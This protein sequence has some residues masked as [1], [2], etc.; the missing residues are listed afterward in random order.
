MA[1]NLESSPLFANRYRF[2]QVPT[3]WDTGRSGFTHLVFDMEKERLG[4]I[5][6]AELK[7]RQAVE[8]LKNEVAVLLDLK[9]QNVPEVYETGEAEYGSKKYFYMVIEYIDG[10][11][12]EK[13][14]SALTVPERADIITQFFDLLANAHKLGIVNG[15]VDLKHLFWRDKKQLVVI[16]WGN[17]KLNAGSKNKTDLAYDLARSAEI[18]YALTTKKGHPPATGSLSLPGNSALFPGLAPLPTEFYELCK[19][20]PRTPVDGAHFKYSA[21]ELLDVSQKWQKAIRSKKAYKAPSK[22]RSWVLGILLL[23]LFL[24]IGFSVISPSS[25]FYNLFHPATVTSTVIASHTIAPSVTNTPIPTAENTET[26]LPPTITNTPPPTPLPDLSPTPITPTAIPGPRVYTT[27][28]ILAEYKEVP[29]SLSSICLPVNISTENNL[30]SN[31]G[32]YPR[33]DSAQEVNYWGFR[34]DKEHT[35]Y[36]KDQTINQAI[37]SDF[38]QCIQQINAISLNTWVTRLDLERDSPNYD[39][40]D[41]GQEI[42][43]FIDNG[44]GLRREYTIWV[45]K[46]KLMHVRVRENNEVVEDSPILVVND[47]IMKIKGTFPRYYAEFPLQIF[48]EINNQGLDII[49]LQEG[50]GQLPV[51]APDIVPE[52]MIRIDNAIFSTVGADQ[53]I[54]IIGYGGETQAI[55]WPFIFYGE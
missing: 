53:S 15:D 42:G 1:E 21:Q 29:S 51:T 47:N 38:G 37:A 23:V 16:D 54:G 28:S 40:V 2:Q 32:F 20:A 31:E 35:I 30:K 52:Q 39:L 10:V 26:S 49:Y 22:S 13:H 3:D 36:L 24:G 4:V 12:I 44:N 33:N 6:R 5:K 18:I 55:I 7:S 48:L 19:W 50:P 34:V 8:E 9:G 27:D 17:A 41:P 11:R 45:D 46:E 25:P 14:L 43:I